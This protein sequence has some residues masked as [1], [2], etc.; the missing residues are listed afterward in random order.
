MLISITTIYAISIPFWFWVKSHTQD[1]QHCQTD[2]DISLLAK[3]SQNMP[4]IAWV[5]R[6]AQFISDCVISPIVLIGAVV[7]SLQ[8]LCSKFWLKKRSEKPCFH[9]VNEFVLNKETKQFFDEVQKHLSPLGLYSKG[10]FKES[11]EG[12]GELVRYFASNN[13]KRFAAAYSLNGTTQVFIGSFTENGCALLL[14]GVSTN[15]F[16]SLESSDRCNEFGHWLTIDE[17]QIPKLMAMH[18]KIESDWCQ[19]NGVKIQRVQP[20]RWKDAF[21]R[22]SEIGRQIKERNESN[23]YVSFAPN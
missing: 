23:K 5:L 14:S 8:T 12:L 21:A 9:Y 15:Q 3:A 16:M 1:C 2:S 7:I 17:M 13:G 18:H 20:Q 10:T 22:F 11:P 4:S 6:P 19:R